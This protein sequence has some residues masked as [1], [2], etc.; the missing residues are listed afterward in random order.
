MCIPF[1]SLPLLISPL[2]RVCSDQVLDHAGSGSIRVREFQDA[3]DF[4]RF[5]LTQVCV[6]CRLRLSPRRTHLEGCLQ[7]VETLS[8]STLKTIMTSIGSKG[9]LKEAHSEMIDFVLRIADLDDDGRLNMAEYVRIQV[10]FARR[11][12]NLRE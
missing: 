10:G 5:S 8:H 7:G 6:R 3:I 11:P 12:R 9:I 4:Y 2:S 1:P